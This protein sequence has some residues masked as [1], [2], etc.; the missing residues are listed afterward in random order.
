VACGDAYGQLTQR[1]VRPSS[2]ETSTLSLAYD[3]I[4]NPSR[5]T[6]PRTNTT[7]LC[8]DVGYGGQ[9]IAGSRGNLTRIIAP[10]PTTGAAPIVTLLRYD[11]KDNVT[12]AVPPKGVTTGGSVTCTTDV[13]ASVNAIF[14]TDLAYDP[15][16]ARLESVTRRFTEPG[17]GQQTAVTKLEYTDAANPG[18]VTRVTPPRGNTGPTPDPAFATTLA[19]FGTGHAS[20]GLL[21][22]VTD[23]LGN[24]ATYEYD[25]VGRRLRMVD[26]LGNTAGGTPG[27]HTWE[28]EYDQEDRPR[29]FRR[30]APSPGEARP[31]TEYRYDAVGNREALVDAKAS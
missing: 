23:P 3:A 21:R 10:P 4:G 17:A 29:F 14:A 7:T 9:P 13:A 20:A 12:Q 11:A 31:V 19:Y 6:D 1:T 27:D 30:P 16:G 8:W 2:S 5:V 18:R 22:S 24:A 15:S 26:K 28:Y 25:G